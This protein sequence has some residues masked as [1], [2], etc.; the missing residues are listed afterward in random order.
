MRLGGHL[1]E[2]FGDPAGWTAAVKRLGYGAAYCPIGADADDETVAA[3]AAGAEAAGIVIAEVGAW[4]NPIS[5]DE[6][7]RADA[8]AG[9]KRQLALAERVGA[10]CCVNIAG[11]R[12]QRWDGPDGDNFSDATFELIVET[13]RE[14]IDAVGPTRSAYTLEPMPWVPPESPDEYLRL[15]EAIDRPAFAVHL[16]P[17]NMINTLRRY[18]DNAGFLRE[19]FAKLGPHIRSVHAKDVSATGEFNVHISQCRPGTG[20]LDYRT[21]L[22]EMD[23]LDADMPILLEHLDT[24][25]EYALAADHLRA[26]AA[27]IGATLERGADG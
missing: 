5:P 10:R 17:A 14:I 19:C 1:Y 8:I 27:E 7:T 16:D 15:I 24:P 13:V 20:G 6:K 9:C 12:G 26:V 21:F 25:E 3:Y 4:S 18:Y 2:G 22:A 11:A 23:K